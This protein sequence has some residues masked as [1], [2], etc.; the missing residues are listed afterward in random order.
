MSGYMKL[1]QL[2]SDL[3]QEWFVVLPVWV[4]FWVTF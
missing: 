1:W 4:T 2:R 3:W